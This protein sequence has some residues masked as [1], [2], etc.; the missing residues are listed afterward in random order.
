MWKWIYG[1]GR[2]V[3]LWSK[4]SESL[5]FFNH[6]EVCLLPANPASWCSTFVCF[7]EC[8]KEC[9][10]KCSLANSAQCSSGPCCNATCLV[11]VLASPHYKLFTRVPNVDSYCCS[12]QFFPRGYSCRYAVNDCDITETCSGDSGQVPRVTP[13]LSF[14]TLCTLVWLKRYTC[15]FFSVPRIFTNKMGTS[16]RLTRCATDCFTKQSIELN[17]NCLVTGMRK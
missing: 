17:K 5:V 4:S 14:Y 3:W 15:V 10:K 6:R 11:C 8:Y 1:G 9:C 7:Q 16:V 2:G 13:T 12:G